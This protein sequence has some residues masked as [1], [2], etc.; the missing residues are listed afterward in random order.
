MSAAAHPFLAPPPR[1][2]RCAPSPRGRALTWL[3][4]AGVHA[5][6]GAWLLHA[7]ASPRAPT[8]QRTMM[9][10]FVREPVA[11]VQPEAPPPPAPPVEPRPAP[12]MIATPT[13]KS[14][15]AIVVPPDVQTRDAPP[16]EAPPPVPQPV[17]VTEA[18]ATANEAI[19]VPPDYKAAYLNNPGPRYP[20]ASRRRREEGVVLLRVRVSATGAPEQVLVDRSS[21]FAEL[22]DAAASVVQQRWRFVPAREGSQPVAAWVAV[23][24]SFE[25][26]NR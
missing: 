14:T 1:A 11:V 24:M 5:A 9:V 4:V 12:R 2:D 26:R 22:D 13:P 20:I 18:A 25:L 19:V 10:S 23:P 16:T 21:G 8:A 17:V 15:S 6:V 7:P 3:A